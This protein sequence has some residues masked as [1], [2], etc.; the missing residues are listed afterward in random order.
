MENTKEKM[1]VVYLAVVKV[2]KIAGRNRGDTR[3]Q[4]DR[5]KR[6]GKRRNNSGKDESAKCSRGTIIPKK[7]NKKSKN[8]SKNASKKVRLNDDIIDE[9]GEYI[10]DDEIYNNNG[11]RLKRKSKELANDKQ[12]LKFRK[13]KK[14]KRIF[15]LIL[16]IVIA[17]LIMYIISLVKWYGLMKN[18]MLCQNSVILDSTGNVIAVIGENRIQENVDYSSVPD[19]L[20]NAYISIE[21]KNFNNH[22]GINFKRTGGA[23]LSYVTHKG[24]ASYGGSTITQQLIKNVTGENETKISRKITEW[25]RAIKTEIIF[26]K[27]D[28]LNAYFNVIYVGPNI[29]G[30]KMGAKYYFDKEVQD[31]S[32]AECAFMAGLTHSPNSYNPFSNKN[33]S[34]RIKDRTKVV[35]NVM[36]Q[37]GHI[38]ED[39]YNMAIQEVDKGLNFKQGKVEPKGDG[40]YSYMADATINE[41]IQDL[42]NDKKISTSFA[43]NLLYF[44]GLQIHSTQ[45]SD[46]QKIIEDECSKNKYLIKSSINKNATSQAAMVII[47][48]KKRLCCRL[49]RRIG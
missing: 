10:E 35:L 22:I 40:V 9:N 12:E 48:Q 1:T 2:V 21:D 44:G 16:F 43:T 45:N 13:R 27:D 11:K 39:D 19:N 20:K 6:D 23:I 42:S 41:V 36:I 47:D 31:L 37:E 3:Q 4:V 28:I 26:S 14:I 38:S 18:I 32:L 25:D 29:Y 7:L 30:V 17:L 24:S 33:N 34:D 15:A 46:V 8:N 49:C 5:K